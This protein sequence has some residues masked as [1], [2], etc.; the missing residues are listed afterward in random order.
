MKFIIEIL[1]IS[2]LE[3]ARVIHR[4]PI[5]AISAERAR[6]ATVMLLES[7]RKRR[8]NAARVRDQKGDE[9]YNCCLSD[10]ER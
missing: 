6:A 10:R 7:W 9:I 4:A 1:R 5:E 2:D 8:A 3:K